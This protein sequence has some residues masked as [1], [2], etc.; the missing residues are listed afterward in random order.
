MPPLSKNQLSK[1]GLR[2]AS[3]E[4]LNAD[5][6]QLF[7]QVIAMYDDVRVVAQ[8]KIKRLL[9]QHFM[10]EGTTVTGR[11]KTTLTLRDK[12][13]RTPEV[14][15]PY[16]RDIA[17]IRV[18]GQLSLRQQTELATLIGSLFDGKPQSRIVDRRAEPVS[19]YRAVHVVVYEAGLPVEVQVRTEL[20]AMWAEIY[21]R[22]A[23][24]WGRQVRYGGPPDADPAGDTETRQRFLET[25]QQISLTTIAN[26]EDVLDRHLASVD[27]D[28]P[29]VDALIR[30]LLRTRTPKGLEDARALM[31]NQAKLRAL[32]P[33][34]AT[35]LLQ[36]RMR[37]R[38]GLRSLAERTD[39]IEW[40]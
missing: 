26:F 28:G 35:A 1:L 5:D 12:L 31:A 30:R 10:H 2:L 17:G 7:E 20:Q 6:L 22:R 27:G 37:I 29:E 23:D 34:M 39:T 4:R 40:S 15:L 21:E 3:G 16:I 11:T 9:E 14:K 13:R 36:W 32:R 8:E 18:V 19:G 33:E 24:A 25:L 38:D